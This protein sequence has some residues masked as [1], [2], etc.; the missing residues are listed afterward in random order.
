MRNVDFDLNKFFKE[1]NKGGVKEKKKMA[2]ERGRKVQTWNSGGTER[3]TVEFLLPSSVGSKTRST[4]VVTT[5]RLL[6]RSLWIGNSPE[7]QR[8]L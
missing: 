5:V 3:A 7:L 6:Q 1:K 8:H 4:A 2:K